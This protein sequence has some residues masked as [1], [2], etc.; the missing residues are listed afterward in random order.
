MELELGILKASANI[1]A[2]YRTRLK[3]RGEVRKGR[4]DAGRSCLP[5]FYH[6]IS[7]AVLF[8]SL[9]RDELLAVQAA[10]H[11]TR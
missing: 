1:L 2:S 7:L 4:G 10:Q 5:L 8:S 11:R 3:Q 6:F 9:A